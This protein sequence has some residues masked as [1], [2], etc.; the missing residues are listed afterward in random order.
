MRALPSQRPTP[1]V[2]TACVKTERVVV[3]NCPRCLQTIHAADDANQEVLCP[4]CSLSIRLCLS[5]PPATLPKSVAPN[6]RLESAPLDP[7]KRWP[8]V[9]NE[10]VLKSFV[11]KDKLEEETAALWE[12]QPR[13]ERH[14]GVIAGAALLAMSLGAIICYLALRPVKTSE[15]RSPMT[16]MM[17]KLLSAEKWEDFLP[18]THDAGRVHPKMAEYYRAGFTPIRLAGARP[19]WDVWEEG[20]RSHSEEFTSNLGRMTLAVIQNP[21]GPRFDWERLVDLPAREWE[22]FLR[23]RPDERRTLRVHLQKAESLFGQQEKLAK[24]ISVKIYLRDAKRAL[25]GSLRSDLI[26]AFGPADPLIPTDRGVEA[27]VDLRFRRAGSNSSEVALE[28]F[29]QW[30]W[31]PGVEQLSYV[32]QEDVAESFWVNQ[33]TLPKKANSGW[34]PEDDEEEALAGTKAKAAWAKFLST[35]DPKEKLDWVIDP[36]RVKKALLRYYSD[37]GGRDLDLPIESWMDPK[38]FL[39]PDDA[40]RGISALVARDPQRSRPMVIFSREGKLDWESYIQ[41]KDDLFGQFIRYPKEGASAEMR[42][43]LRRMSSDSSRSLLVH[44]EDLVPSGESMPLVVALGSP[45]AA[46]FAKQ[47][48]WTSDRTATIRLRWRKSGNDWQAELEKFICWDLFSF[49][50]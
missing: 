14:L 21:D 22:D 38:G 2:Q 39:G 32:G 29:R 23:A 48:S 19:R 30:G 36:K 40:K 33:Q 1:R 26:T 3:L 15:I 35:K 7:R 49:S 47:L 16:V 50:S 12:E 31:T 5:P 20:Q 34:L 25:F 42:V 41:V 6:F 11:A 13:K 24:E 17:E 43:R 27:V 37:L 44:I 8:F 10:R 28:G 45:M 9:D 18:Y 46:E 4:K